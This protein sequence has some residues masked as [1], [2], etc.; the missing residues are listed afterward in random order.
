MMT[1]HAMM[2]ERIADIDHLRANGREGGCAPLFEGRTEGVQGADRSFKGERAGKADGQP[3]KNTPSKERG[4]QGQRQ[5]GMAGM[6]HSIV[7]AAAVAT[8]P[9]AATI[10][11]HL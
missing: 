10:T 7:S 11:F 3:S 6:N 5:R 9:S 4:R 1:I 2:Q 8:K